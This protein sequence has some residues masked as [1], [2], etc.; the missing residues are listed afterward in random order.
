[1]LG[2]SPERSRGAVPPK[3]SGE[4]PKPRACPARSHRPAGITLVEILIVIGLIALLLAMLLPAMIKARESARRVACLSNVR[5]LVAVTLIYAAEN[6]QTLPE[7]TSANTPL[8]SPVCPRR[9]LLP[10]WTPYAPERYVLPSIGGLLDKYLK[11]EGRMWRCPSAPD[12]SYILEGPDPYNG[13]LGVPLPASQFLPNYNYMAGKEFFAE[14]ALGG[15]IAA[16]FMLR[17]WASRNVSGLR[18]ARVVPTPRVDASRIVLFHD[19]A[20]V[21]HSRGSRN[22][23]TQP[24]D[25]TY[26]ASYGYMD[27]HAQ[28]QSY[29]NKEEYLAQIHPAIP[30]KWFGAEFAASLPEQYPGQ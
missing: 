2:V 24:G 1:G 28:G 4:T 15:P 9:R 17:E 22:I 12:G 18:I 21:Y 13:H 16:T 7:A 20:S 23:Y 3:R 8:E 6:Q 19:R 11:N 14:A 27:G 25:W 30:Q 29:R 10:P 26:Y 5:Q